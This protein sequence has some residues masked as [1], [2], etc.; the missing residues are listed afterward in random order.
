MKDCM[1]SSPQ[2]LTT[3]K[4]LLGVCAEFA[5][6]VKNSDEILSSELE[7]F[8]DEVAKFDLRFSSVLFSLLDRVAQL[9]REN[10]NERIVNILSRL[11]FNG[12]YSKAVEAFGNSAA[13]SADML[14]SIN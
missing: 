8:H 4:K 1:L 5:D 14:D 3:V 10:N 2:L 6:F 7:S 12:F 11:D 13:T 9:G